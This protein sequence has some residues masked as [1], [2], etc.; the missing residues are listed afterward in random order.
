V[1]LSWRAAASKALRALRDGRRRGMGQEGHE[2]FSGRL[3]KRCF[4][5]KRFVL[6]IGN[7]LQQD[8]G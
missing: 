4:A 6:Q 2:K 8:A 1:K 3:E 5:R 7:L